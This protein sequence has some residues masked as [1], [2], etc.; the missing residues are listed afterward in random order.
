MQENLHFFSEL[1]TWGYVRMLLA[2]AK[3]DFLLRLYAIHRSRFWE[4]YGSSRLQPAQLLK[5]PEA[6][7]P[8]GR[9]REAGA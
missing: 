5:V 3:E 4:R 6:N 8:D 2:A 7:R 1:L 9:I